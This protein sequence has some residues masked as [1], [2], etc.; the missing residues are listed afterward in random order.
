MKVPRLGSAGDQTARLG[1]ANKSEIQSRDGRQEAVP[2]QLQTLTN[3]SLQARQLRAIHAVM[4]GSPQTQ[5]LQAKQRMLD[6][7]SRT[8]NMQLGVKGVAQAVSNGNFV[9]REL[10]GQVAVSIGNL[11][12]WD[13]GEFLAKDL[14]EESKNEKHVHVFPSLTDK[15]P[16]QIAES[17]KFPGHVVTAKGEGGLRN[18][19]SHEITATRGAGDVWAVATTLGERVEGV[20]GTAAKPI[21]N[22]ELLSAALREDTVEAV[23]EMLGMSDEE[24]QKQQIDSL[25]AAKAELA[26][27]KADKDAWHVNALALR[28]QHEPDLEGLGSIFGGDE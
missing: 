9:G 10:L 23:E 1:G 5:H 3:D 19:T 16:G 17:V 22:H 13:G 8:S 25:D 7:G 24:A 15:P 18:R 14:S 12:Q 20:E 4:N 21:P 28:D 27:S 6:S 11:K 2:Q 26:K